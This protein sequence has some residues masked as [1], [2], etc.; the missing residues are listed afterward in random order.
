[1][2]ATP[3]GSFGDLFTNCGDIYRLHAAHVWSRAG[4]HACRGLECCA[5]RHHYK[6]FMARPLRHDVDCSLPD[7]GME[8]HSDNRASECGSSTHHT[9]PHRCW[10]CTLLRRCRVPRVE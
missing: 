1:M 10:W 6:T 7:N 3:L 2:V 9:V 4:R 5:G 8:P